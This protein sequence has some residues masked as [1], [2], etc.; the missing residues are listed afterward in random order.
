MSAAECKVIATSP[1]LKLKEFVEW[2]YCVLL[3]FCNNSENKYLE[4]IP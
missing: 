3:E 1:A 4:L 2:P